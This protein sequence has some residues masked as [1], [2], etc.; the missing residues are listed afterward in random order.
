[1]EMSATLDG[2]WRSMLAARPVKNAAACVADTSGEAV[3]I[4]IKREKPW[5]MVPPISWIV[6]MCSERELVLDRMGARIWRLCDGER[7][8]EDVVDVFA[9]RHALTFHEARAAVT[10]YVKGLIQRGAMA[11]V[12]REDMVR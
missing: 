6:P 4:Q 11:I 10:G 2:S 1:M 5:Y 8:I 12:V 9:E 3:T 7:T